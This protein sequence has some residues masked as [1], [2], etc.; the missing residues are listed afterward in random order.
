MQTP[1]S[2][3]LPAI[4][5]LTRPFW[6]A[7]KQGRLAIQR[8][9]NCG[10]F[11]HPPRLLCDRCLSDQLAFEA[12]SG[13]GRVWSFS[14]MH[15]KHIL[16]FEESVPYLTALVELDEQP[17][18]LLVTNLPGLRPEQVQIGARVRVTFEPLTDEV[19]LPQFV[20]AE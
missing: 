3:P 19:F 4:D 20:P 5:D 17:M 8:C 16:G 7:A 6:E 18:L 13:L 12:V 14:V 2:R 10:Y 11:N 15:Q 9:R 1:P